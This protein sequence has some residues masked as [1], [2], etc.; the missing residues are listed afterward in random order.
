MTDYKLRLGLCVARFRPFFRPARPNLH[1]RAGQP[2]EHQP[3]LDNLPDLL[4][5]RR[6][7]RLGHRGVRP[8][9]AQLSG[10][11]PHD[12]L[13]QGRHHFHQIPATGVS[14]LEALKHGG[15]VDR[16]CLSRLCRWVSVIPLIGDQ[17]DLPRRSIL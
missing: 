12:G 10:H 13:R 15:L 17:V 5:H 11:V 2:G 8:P 16:E 6:V 7:R 9:V 1:L 3:V 14:E 4:L